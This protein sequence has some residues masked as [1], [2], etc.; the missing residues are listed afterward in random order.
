MCIRDSPLPSSHSKS[1]VIYISNTVTST[2]IFSEAL[3]SDL[4]LVVGSISEQYCEW[5]PVLKLHVCSWSDI[6][7][8]LTRAVR[9]CFSVLSTGGLLSLFEIEAEGRSCKLM[10]LKQ[11]RETVTTLHCSELSCWNKG[12]RA[13]YQIALLCLLYLYRKSKYN[14]L[15]RA[16]N[17]ECEVAFQLLYPVVI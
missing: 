4:R 12:P 3:F 9:N 15:S 1:E 10:M 7:C 14:Q 5:F 11:F 13:G 17:W 8:I 6:L 2:G 16:T